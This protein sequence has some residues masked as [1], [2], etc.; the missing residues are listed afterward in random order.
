MPGP[1]SKKRKAARNA[2]NN[3]KGKRICA[4]SVQGS[5]V[6]KEFFFM[7]EMFLMEL[8][9]RCDLITIFTLA[10]AS[11]YARHLVKLFFSCNLRLLVAVFVSDEHVKQFFQVLEVSGSAIAGSVT[12][13]VLT[14]PYRHAWKPLNLNIMVPRGHL[15]MWE[16]F[17]VFINLARVSSQPGVDRKYQHTT[18]NHVVY[19]SKTAGFNITLTESRDNSVL[20]P[21]IGATTTFATNLATSAN[22]Y[23]LYPYLTSNKRALEGWYPTPVKQAV[24]LGRRGIRSSFSTASW[25]RPCGVNCPIRWREV[26]GLRGVG[27]FRWGGN[28]NQHADNTEAG[29]PNTD[30]DMK[31]R[32]GDTCN[33][34]HCPWNKGNYFTFARND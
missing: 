17:L 8:L 20:S 26:K 27:V 25:D 32:L 10:K 9:P 12:S 28:E 3:K 6:A 2:C 1:A 7:P 19:S 18:F 14:F 16:E 21:L 24:T 34:R 15:F 33:N 13:A 29:I 4:D 31:W 30:T 23:S 11:E 22:F 5:A